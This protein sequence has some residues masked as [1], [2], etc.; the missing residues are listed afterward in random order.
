MNLLDDPSLPV[1]SL[2]MPWANWVMLGWK[3]IET[4]LHPRF[5]GLA[6]KRIAIHAAQKWDDNA[7]ATAKPYLTYEQHAQ[8][9]GFLHTGG[10]IL[11][12]VEVSAHR[13]LHEEDAKCALIEC[14]SVQRYGL[15]LYSPQIIEAI[16]AK[17][18]QGIWYIPARDV[19]PEG[20]RSSGMLF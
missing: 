16:P 2:W 3:S 11:G 8:S 15:I 9:E 4:R 12:T 17:G 1:I 14:S 20:L 19:L 7:L 5:A 10:A 18:R 6:G 13:S